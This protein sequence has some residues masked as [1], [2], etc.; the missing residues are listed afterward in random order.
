MKRNLKL[1]AIWY[2]VKFNE[3]KPDSVGLTLPKIESFMAEELKNEGFILASKTDPSFTR[4]MQRIL[5]SKLKGNS[6][7]T[8]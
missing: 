2:P 1:K 5:R 6:H 4:I 7:D 8:V 3:G